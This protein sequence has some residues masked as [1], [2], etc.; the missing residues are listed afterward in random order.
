MLM[1]P[2]STSFFVVYTLCGLSDILDGYVARKTNTVSKLGEVLDSIADFVFV[3]TMLVIFILIISWESWM[4]YWITGV[5]LVRFAALGVG[6][7]KYSAFSFL[8]TYSN[9]A[10]GLVLF[11]F[12]LIYLAAGLTITTV[13]IGSLASLSALEE[14]IIT[15]HSKRLDRNVCSVFACAQEK[16]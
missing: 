2:L 10:T 1:E 5:A 8:H 13:I 14:L 9:K 7:L 12:P 6:Y 3:I 4:L 15:I 11:C 16:E